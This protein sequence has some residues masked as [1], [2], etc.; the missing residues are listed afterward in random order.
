ML[1]DFFGGKRKDRRHEM[2]Q[3]IKNVIEG[4]L[5]GTSFSGLSGFTVEAILDDIQVL[6][7]EIDAAK[8]VQGVIDDVKFEILVGVAAP[9]KQILRAVENPTV[10]FWQTLSDRVAAGLEII[11][12]TDQKACCISQLSVSLYE[13][14]DD[15]VRDPNV[16]AVILGRRPEP[17]D[18]GAVLLDDFLR[19]DDVAEGFGHL[20]PFAVQG[21]AVSEHAA[22][23]WP[24][25]RRDGGEQGG[26][27]P[28][29]M[30]I[31]A[32]Q[33]EVRYPAELGAGFHDGRMTDPRIKPDVQNVLLLRKFPVAARRTSEMSWQQLACW[34]LKP[35]V[36][37]RA[38]ENRADVVAKLGTQDRV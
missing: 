20:A 23:R 37:A 19:R 29:A 4:R 3:R 35:G 8:V 33:V 28:T 31:A 26:M 7:A 6:G 15:F 34:P 22:I 12:V 11:E 21:E 24:R 16:L 27:K 1:P 36:G 2:N 18:F 5:C 9:G 25:A 32:L 14:I 38:R 17:E 30:L 10:E 13:A